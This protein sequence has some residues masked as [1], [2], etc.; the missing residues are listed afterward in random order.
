MNIEEI[1]DY[2]LSELSDQS[3]IPARDINR[4][5][6]LYDDLGI[7]DE[8]LELAFSTLYE[9]VPVLEGF[10]GTL[11]AIDSETVGELLDAV[12]DVVVA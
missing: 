8:A 10:P 4:D 3:G 9:F 7:D 5:H 1:S 2:I 6:K 11:D 12:S